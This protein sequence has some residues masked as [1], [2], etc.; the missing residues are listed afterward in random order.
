V[1]AAGIDIG[2]STTEVLVAEVTPE[3]VIPLVARRAWTIGGKGSEQSLQA[4]A[5]L[6]LRV[7]KAAGRVCDVLLLAPLNPVL[8]LS[9]SIPPPQGGRP[10]LRTLGD[11]LAGTP[12]GSGFAVGRHLPLAEL[13]GE[14]G[15]GE[16]VVVSV[17]P[18]VDFE[19]AAAGIAHAQDRDLPVVAAVVAE[20][21]AVLIANRIL[22]AI[23]IVDEVDVGG[24]LPGE[25]IAVEVAA[26]GARV[27]ILSDPVA[28]VAA[29]GLSPDEAPLLTDLTQSLADARCAALALCRDAD[30]G[31]ET[32]DVGWLDYE[33]ESGPSRVPLDSRIVE[34]AQLVRPGSVHRLVI[35]AGTPLDEVMGDAQERV[36]DI[37]AVDLPSIKD[38]FFPR[39]GSVALGDVPLSVLLAQDRAAQPAESVLERATGRRV[40]V[41][42]GEAEA[43]ALGALT[44]PGAAGD[45]A[46]CDLGGGTIDLVCGGE[47]VTAA[48]AGDL[49]TTAVSRAL[50]LQIRSAEYVKRFSSFR[51]EGPHVVHY[52]DGSRGFVDASLPADT[53][54]RLCYQ[55]GASAA[56][57]S[58]LLAPE[59]WRALRLAIKK[60]VIGAS[61]SRCLK[62]LTA[63]PRLVL[64]C[65]GAALDAEA[66]RIVGDALRHTGT[67]VGKANVAGRYGPRYG[68][69]L[70]LLLA[71][72]LEGRDADAREG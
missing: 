32:T 8:T 61:V 1:I 17:P 66:V 52:E 33:G 22:R 71:Y 47:H 13:A 28:L 9:A 40:R 68:V 25:L 67:T 35:P 62:W 37:F 30:P 38:R 34:Y 5:R 19:E 64:L 42:A 6:L 18:G 36:R 41:V 2:N 54:G 70:G 44:T 29:F 15:P 59:E 24:L 10:P 16:D 26:A 60:G 46:V 51:A 20:D 11:P 3:S 55:R 65:G 50:N 49:L 23:P 57:F 4:A 72:Q 53:L 56:P 43:A 21:D 63:R 7:E 39:A 27:Q 14:S 31:R 48:G 12:S 69:A 45:A 58:D